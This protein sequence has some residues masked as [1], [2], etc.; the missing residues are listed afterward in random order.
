MK[1]ILQIMDVFS[2][3]D[4]RE[5][6][7]KL[8]KDNR[9]TD[10]KNIALFKLIDQGQTQGLGE[11][12]YGPGS[13]NAYHALCKRLQ[14]RMIDFIATRNFEEES[15]EELEILKLLLAAR[16]F[17]EHKKPSLGF[18]LLKRAERKA[19]DH[20][21]YPILNE[22]YHTNI[23][24]AHLN[25]ALDLEELTAKSDQNMESFQAEFRLNQAYAQIKQKLKSP[26][27]ESISEIIIDTFTSFDIQIDTSL[28]FKALHQL[29]TI[30]VAAAT[31]ESD[32]F[33]I[34]PVM[35][36]LYAVVREK[37][38]QAR[39]HL[40]Y[41]LE[42][43]HLMALMYF[44]RKDFARSMQLANTMEDVML[45]K[46]RTLHNRFSE[47]LIII[48]ALN[49]TY[50]GNAASAIK[51]LESLDQPSIYTQLLL[52]T[53][54]FLTNEHERA[55]HALREFQHSD[56]WYEKKAGWIWVLKKNIIEMLLLIELD[57]LDLFLNRLQS[58]KRRFGK[59]L[60]A[61]DEHRVIQFLQ[62]VEHYYEGPKQVITPEFEERVEA[63]FEWRGSDKEDIFVMSFYAWLKAKMQQKPLYEV[64]LK[65]VS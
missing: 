31:E 47:K 6:L 9:R 53:C 14:D 43:L 18:K 59:Q 26:G 4:K 30:C 64:T 34:A 10:V 11:S 21:L 60:K 29:M 52:T 25:P 2:E 48:K 46:N 35:E 55:Y 3:E 12:L 13:R 51:R 19:T 28:T 49:E 37:E 38:G 41:Y 44:R 36:Q 57:K 65:L 32:Y 56:G 1:T 45:G 40:F 50:T 63:T 5:F 17:F 7:Q 62:L 22:I 61:A 39:K 42:I 23:Q 27:G 58:F 33:L 8:G 54:L 15:S 16:I 24:F 20:D